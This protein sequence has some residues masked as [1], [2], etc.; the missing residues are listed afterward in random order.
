MQHD[1]ENLDHESLTSDHPT[2]SRRTL[3]LT[4]EGVV[5]LIIL[6][7]ITFGAILRNVNL[8]IVLAGMM[9]SA[10]TLNWRS[11]LLKSKTITGYRELPARVYA[12][13][14]FSVIWR[15]QNDS[16]QRIW[17]INVEDRTDCDS[18]SSESVPIQ[19]TSTFAQLRQ[20]IS[21]SINRRRRLGPNQ[22]RLNFPQLPPHSTESNIY[23][24]LLNQRGRYRVGPS[25]IST[26]FPFGLIEVELQIENRQIIYAAP[27][28]GKLV[29]D[30]ERRA[31]AMAAGSESVK[32][33]RGN[34]EDEFFALRQWRSGDNRK[35]IHWRSTAKMQQP[36]VR[37]FDEPTHRDLAIVIDLFASKRST[38]SPDQ[39]PSEET[40][41][42][43]QQQIETVLSFASTIAT[44]TNLEVAGQSSIAICGQTNE[45]FRKIKRKNNDANLMRCLAMAHSSDSPDLPSAITAVGES[46]SAGT[47]IFIIST[48]AQPQWVQHLDP[49][50]KKSLQ[51]SRNDVFQSLAYPDLQ[52]SR[53]TEQIRW[54]DARSDE[55]K[56][57]FTAS[58]SVDEARIDQFQRRW[59]RAE[60]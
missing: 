15:I 31:A 50:P 57:L 58:A 40:P 53:L 22:V 9:V 30:W 12:G 59:A 7:F 3:R 37:Q 4:P 38:Q 33:K 17:N 42:A 23:H 20:Q 5:F 55:F 41:L 18:H 14:L 28:T 32:R 29:P 16:P 2:I 46:V 34:H 1:H 43:D 48:R 56:M 60:H 44:Q 6:G 11:A 8:L 21:D 26:T 13:K 39:S 25:T 51:H 27:P 24:C 19:S 45:V 54:I 52:L 36:M 49:D 35:N 10:I 47:P